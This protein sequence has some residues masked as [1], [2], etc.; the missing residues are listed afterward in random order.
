MDSWIEMEPTYLTNQ[1]LIYKRG[2]SIPDPEVPATEA[3]LFTKRCEQ[4]KRGVIRK[5]V[6]ITLKA[7]GPQMLDAL[8]EAFVMRDDVRLLPQAN[9][10][11]KQ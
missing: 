1:P 4:R 7:D 3:Y 9:P 6:V 11:A 2:N 10:E 5:N 8:I